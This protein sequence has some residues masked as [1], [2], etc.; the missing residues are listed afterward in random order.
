MPTILSSSQNPLEPTTPANSF[1]AIP[2]EIMIDILKSM[3]NFKA[4]TA[5]ASTSHKLRSIWE[6]NSATICHAILV[7]TIACIDPA[8]DYVK[9]QPPNAARLKKIK[10]TGL[11]AIE[12]TKQI[13]EN[14]ATACLA[15]QYYED[16]I[17]QPDSAGTSIASSSTQSQRT[18]FLQAWYRIHTLASL[19]RDPLPCEIFASLNL[20]QF[21]E[22][23]EVFCW[24]MYCCPQEHRFELHVSYRMEGPAWS[25]GLPKS[26]ISPLRWHNLEVC[27]RSLTQVMVEKLL[28][29]RW[30]KCGG[31]NFCNILAHEIYLNSTM[32]K[33]GVGPAKT[34]PQIENLDMSD[35]GLFP[36]YA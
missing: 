33:K 11:M 25:G 18:W 4:A 5:L 16:Q 32:S 19:S 35:L 13:C 29:D 8:F 20:L 10:D 14:D 3:P 17:V 36:G 6:T 12:A 15:L 27:L 24:L 1:N 30:S 22:M 34:T 7:H 21:Q 9:A 31:I 2:T 28:N 26:L 23:M